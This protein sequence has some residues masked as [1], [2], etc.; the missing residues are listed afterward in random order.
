MIV[1]Y[2]KPSVNS[3]EHE[4]VL[5]S[6]GA[7]LPWASNVKDYVELYRQFRKYGNTGYV[8]HFRLKVNGKWDRKTFFGETAWSDVERYAAD[9]YGVQVQA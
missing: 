7:V 5:V 6:M 1:D 8:D 9:Q 4:W 2:K 3:T